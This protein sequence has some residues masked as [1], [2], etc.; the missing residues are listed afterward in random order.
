MAVSGRAGAGDALTVAAAMLTIIVTT[1]SRLDQRQVVLV[2]KVASLWVEW[3][4]RFT[5]HVLRLT[6][7]VSRFTF[8]V[9]RFTERKRVKRK[10]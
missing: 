2:L 4:S 10:E 1:T 9:L 5:F 3:G 8:H 7:Y 6:F